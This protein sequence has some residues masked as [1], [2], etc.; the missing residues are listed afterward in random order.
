MYPTSPKSPLLSA[1]WTQENK[2]HELHIIQNLFWLQT[3]S[4]VTNHAHRYAR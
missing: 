2:D 4:D 1:Y 3:R